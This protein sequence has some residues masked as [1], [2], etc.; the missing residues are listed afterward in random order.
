[1]SI[2]ATLTPTENGAN[3][4]IDINANFLALNTDKA[5]NS[6]LAS[7]VLN[8][9]SLTINGTTYD[10]SANRTWTTGDVTWGGN[11][12]GTKKLIG[13]NDNYDIGFKTNGSEVVTILNTGLVGIGTTAPIYKL[14]VKGLTASSAIRSD[15][16]FDIYQVP[17]P[18][19]PTG[20]VSA[21]GS[22]DTGA[23]WY[24]VT[25][26]TALGE[27]H[28]TY[29][30]AQIT[31]TAGNN[32]I[33]LTIPTST[34]PR[35]T[36]RKIYRTKVGEAAYQEYFLATIANNTTT[37]YVDTTADSSLT[38]SSGVAYFRTNTTSNQFTVNGN[39][40]MTLDSKGTYI[41]YGAGAT[42]TTGG[43]N[44]IVGQGAGNAIT[45]AAD[46]V[47]IGQ[48]AAN[49][50]TSGSTNTFI[51]SFSGNK[52]TIGNSNTALGAYS[53][54]NV[55]SGITN[56]GLGTFSLQNVT[57][58]GNTA[59]GYDSLVNIGNSTSNTAIGYN[60][61]RY[62]AD[63][64]TSKTTGDYGVYIGAGVKSNADGTTNEIV[65]GYNAVG[66]GSN[67]VTYGNTSITKHLFTNGNMG[68]G[69]TAPIDTLHIVS[70]SNRFQISKSLGDSVSA[71]ATLDTATCSY[72]HLGGGEYANNSYRLMTFGY[73]SST[74]NPT[75]PAAYLG[76]Q[77]ISTVGSTK[78]DLIFGTRSVTTDTIPTE[79]MRID[80]AGNVGIGVAGPTASL[81]IKAGSATAGTAPIKL[82][83]G[84]V[85]TAPE[86]GAI[87]WDGTDLFITI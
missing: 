75:N 49:G 63:G 47:L 23:H 51:G 48:S 14:D 39:K 52:I 16:G 37:T 3:S 58:N 85:M 9:R 64:S 17:D 11:T 22:V 67:T 57:G 30:A 77:E 33:T 1:M 59:V 35:V 66:N 20:V 44:I 38:G 55:V 62:I 6:S 43:R 12:N 72:I 42:T 2:L 83:A 54:M 65:I 41:G 74:T 87:E 15:M 29:T 25:Y 53:L 68:I 73:K 27:T 34:D 26:V 45:T 50:L 36:A 80:N 69:T 5:E 71:P 8:T 76:Y 21:G 24:G 40:Y 19:A 60:A 78:G 70:S 86:S 4:L 84:T 31:T 56:T 7:Y 18:V 46:L 28:I 10:L 32:T 81:N 13:S 82:T 79:R 61:G